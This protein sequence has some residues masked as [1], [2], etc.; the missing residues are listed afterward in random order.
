MTKQTSQA[1]ISTIG[2]SIVDLIIRHCR[3]RTFYKK[4]CQRFYGFMPV[5]A[6]FFQFPRKPVH[7]FLDTNC[8]F[9]GKCRP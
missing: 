6:V 2:G 5:R 9:F 1:S 3:W 8:P 7:V 4:G